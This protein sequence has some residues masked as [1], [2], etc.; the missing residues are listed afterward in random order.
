MN[1]IEAVMTRVSVRRFRD[2]PVSEEDI[3]TILKAGMSGPSC[4]NARDWSFIVVQDKDRPAVY[5]TVSASGTSVLPI[6]LVFGDSAWDAIAAGEYY[7]EI[8]YNSY[9]D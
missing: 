5:G 2:E 7:M 9:L 8:F 1:T 3:R 6:T 4:V